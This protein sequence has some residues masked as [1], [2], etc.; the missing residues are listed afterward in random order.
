[1]WKIFAYSISLILFLNCRLIQV[2]AQDTIPIPLKIKVG[3]EVSGPAI[4]Y[5][6]KN[7]LNEE[8]YI[9]VDLDEKYSA[10]LAAGYLNFKYSQYNY[11]YFNRGSFI[12]IGMDF[13]LLKPDKSQGKYWAGI[14]LRYG[15]S[16]F[17][18][19][20]PSFQMTDYWGTASSSLPSKTNW[21][22]FLEACPGV[23]A[24][25][26]NH[27]SIGWSISIRML[28]Y[29]GTGRDLRPVYFPGFGD[30]TKTLAAG[31]NYYIVWNIPYKKINAILKKPVPE[32]TEDT[33]DNSDKSNSGTSGTKANRQQGS[34]IRQ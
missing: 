23:R 9:S 8:G 33:E 18:S 28:L 30:G 29:T 1:M 3:L 25:I 15:L 10:V 16:R 5:S 11:T 14:G 21:G 2:Q 7:I 32:D 22:H 13:N 4:Y 24:E 31:M 6:D 34:M 19:K 26:F 27:F 20:V 12:R 17:N